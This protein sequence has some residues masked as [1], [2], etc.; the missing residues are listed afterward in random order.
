M[1]GKLFGYSKT[2]VDRYLVQQREAYEKELSSMS[3]SIQ[4]Y[5]QERIRLMKELGSLHEQSQLPQE[6]ELLEFAQKRVQKSVHTLIE[7]GN[8]E[9][10]AI[11]KEASIKM[12]VHDRKVGEIEK[13]IQAIR[14]QIAHESTLIVKQLSDLDPSPFLKDKPER[15]IFVNEKNLQPQAPKKDIPLTGSP[16]SESFWGQGLTFFG[17]SVKE[18][19]MD[20]NIE[21]KSKVEP[22]TGN[23]VQ[24]SNVKITN[25]YEI[26]DRKDSASLSEFQEK[27]DLPEEPAAKKANPAMMKEIQTVRLKYIVGKL[28]GEDLLNSKG[29]VLIRKNEQ[30][31]SNIVEAAA[32]EGKLAEL[33]V[34][35]IIPGLE[36]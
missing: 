28:A 26:P 16:R 2:E 6:K 27:T 3:E 18:I 17:N 31:T 32:T 7:I 10:S 25:E 4:H 30:I 1:K 9:A 12:S 8:K 15:N 11:N 22:Y 24:E 34:K 29:E 13:E 33:I 36:G 14:S 21:T 5:R 19:P 20:K 23:D 35:M